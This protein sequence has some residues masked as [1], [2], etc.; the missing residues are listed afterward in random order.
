MKIK[1]LMKTILV[2][3]VICCVPVLCQAA[4]QPEDIEISNGKLS[5]NVHQ[6]PFQEVITKISEKA[7]V[8]IYVFDNAKG[9]YLT[10]EFSGRPLEAGLR[11]ILK[12]VNYAIVY[13][14]DH[15]SGNVHWFKS[16]DNRPLSGSN[17]GHAVMAEKRSNSN[18]HRGLNTPSQAVPE[19]G[20]MQAVSAGANSEGLITQDKRDI[21]Y[22][23]AGGARAGALKSVQGD[24]HSEGDDFLDEQQGGLENI[25][26][27][28]SSNEDNIA[29]VEEETSSK[30]LPAWYKGNM[31]K[32]EARL[33]Y[34]IQTL[35]NDIDSG[36]ADSQYD[37]WV[38]IRGP[39]YIRHADEV[40]AEYEERLERLQNN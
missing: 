5:I 3:L 2:A 32:E 28:N 14:D 33:R 1:Y 36:Y 23:I 27:N 20:R 40:I 10:A 11:S 6:A 9:S 12:G 7:G 8:Y 16:T 29:A 22:T 25:N 18:N 21:N 30:E 26:N 31:S 38:E 15:E 24:A 34:R 4:K 19:T 17:K 35:E 13:Q 37:R 39:K